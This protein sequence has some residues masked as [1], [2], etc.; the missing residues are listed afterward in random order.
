MKYLAT[1]G[2]GVIGS[3]FAQLMAARGDHVTIIDSAEE[4][5]NLWMWDQLI[6]AHPNLISVHKARVEETDFI[7][8]LKTHDAILHAA[9]HTGIPHSAADPDD[10]WTSN[11]DATRVI[12]EA[13]RKTNSKIPAVMLSSVKPYRVH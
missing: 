11:V 2:L 12:L 1:G 7:P 4:P 8:L 5:R 3:R 9:A 6:Q 10:D 13:M